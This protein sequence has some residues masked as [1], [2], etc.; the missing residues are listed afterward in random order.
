MK[1]RYILLGTILLL[2]GIGTILLPEKK[3][4]QQV[5]ANQLL[6]ELTDDTRF[7]KTIE[8]ADRLIKKDPTLV[9]IDVR[10]ASA[11]EA[12][13]LPGAINIPLEEFNKEEHQA[14]LNQLARDNV[15]I[16]NGGVMADQGWILCKRK[17]Y[18][19]NYVMHGGMN[20][21]VESILRPTPPAETASRQAHEQYVKCKAASYY[22]GGGSMD[23]KTDVD[24][25]PLPVIRKNKKRKIEGGC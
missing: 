19:N 1:K 12:Y 16:S 20:R 23:V 13:H 25:K 6:L 4:P 22:F 15:F 17:G 21:W 5:K 7:I 9:L 8:V 2:L 24:K 10:S 14:Y 3:T 18:K 11:Y